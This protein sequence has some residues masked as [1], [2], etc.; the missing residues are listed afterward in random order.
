MRGGERDPLP[1]VDEVSL[2]GSTE[3]FSGVYD[4]SALFLFWELAVRGLLVMIC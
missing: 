2:A 1:A 4:G 3:G